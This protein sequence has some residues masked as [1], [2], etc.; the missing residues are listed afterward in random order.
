[1]RKNFLTVAT[2]YDQGFIAK[3]VERQFAFDGPNSEVKEPNSVL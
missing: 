2:E 3:Y 1:M